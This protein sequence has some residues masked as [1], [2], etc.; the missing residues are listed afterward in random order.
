MGETDHLRQEE[1]T[2]PNASLGLGVPGWPAIGTQVGVPELGEP[3]RRSV[4]T[5]LC[6]L[7][8]FSQKN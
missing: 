8:V 7:S 6:V 5:A 4:V 3:G 1:R 2:I